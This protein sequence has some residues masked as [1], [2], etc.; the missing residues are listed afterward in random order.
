MIDSILL[1]FSF[2][3]GIFAFFAPCAVALLPGYLSSF[4][5]RNIEKQRQKKWLLLKRAIF[6][7]FL[8]I[9]GITTIYG[10]ASLAIM[11]FASIIKKVIIYLGI[12]LGVVIIVVGIF[13]IKGKTLSFQLH[14]PKTKSKNQAIESYLF[15]ISYGIGSLACLFPFFLVVATSAIQSG[16]FI[17]GSSYFGAYAMGM[18]LFMFGFYILAVF[19]KDFLQSSV[20]KI[21]PYLHMVGGSIIILAGLYIIWY[22]G[23]TLL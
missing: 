13:M 1:S 10:L 8:T 12:L 15:G 23:G 3:Q 7:S 9:L 20:S 19:A 16:S 6:F 17:V 22:Q 18:S 21:M 5:T 4:V 11:L 14:G 2:T